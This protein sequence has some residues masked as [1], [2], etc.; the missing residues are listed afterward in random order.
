[1]INAVTNC[2]VPHLTVNM[3]ASYGAGNYGMSGRAYDPRFLF[4]W[5]NAKTAV[6]GPEQ[7]A[8]VMSI[9]GPAV[10]GVRRPAVRRGGRR[11]A[12]AREL[13]DQIEARVAR[14]LHDAASSTTTASSTPATPAPCSASRCP[15]CTRTTSRAAA[16]SA[17]SGCEAPDEPDHASCSSPTAARSR[18]GSCAPRRAWAS[19][20]V[21]VYSDADADAPFVREADEA[22]RARRRDAGRVLP[23]RRRDHRRGASP[24]GADAVHP[25]YGFLSENAAFARACADAGLTFVG[26]PP[27]RSRPWARSS[28]PRS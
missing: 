24:T 4:T 26:P 1:M 11:R 14:L 10:R 8:G 27:R 5:P 3:G 9:V 6:M 28:R 7:L 25:G 21:A 20:T 17:C 23:A 12:A 2:T 15:P 19:R 22:V 18:A 13:E 16:A